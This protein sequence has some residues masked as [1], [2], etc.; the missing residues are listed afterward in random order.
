MKN[1]SRW[2]STSLKTAEKMVPIR[3]VGVINE[4]SELKSVIVGHTDEDF[5]YPMANEDVAFEYT[6][7]LNEDAEFS[8]FDKLMTECVDGMIPSDFIAYENENLDKVAYTLSSMGIDVYRPGRS[9]TRDDISYDYV[10]NEH[11]KSKSYMQAHC[12]RDLL[13]V[14]ENKVIICPT[15]LRGR[16]GEIDNFYGDI[17]DNMREHSNES[18]VEI[19]DLR[20]YSPLCDKNT[21]NE[22]ENVI[23][24]GKKGGKNVTNIINDDNKGVSF[25][26]FDA[27]N[28][29]KMGQNQLLYLVSSSGNMLGY[30][31]LQKTVGS[32]Y[33]I[34]PIRG[35]Y[36]ANHVD[37]T[38]CFLNNKTVLYNGNRLDYNTC[39]SLLKP[40]GFSKFIPCTAR[41]LY[42]NGYKYTNRG[43]KW[44]GM[45]I[46]MI[47]PEL[48]MIDENQKELS[49]LL[50]DECGIHSLGVKL[51]LARDFGG[52]CH[53]VTLD[54]LRE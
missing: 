39:E 18:G 52:G 49:D 26:F 31:L 20:E 5:R 34:L 2:H 14:V 30:D 3:K 1:M 13:L 47:N 16:R 46:L 38:F 28:I 54:L 44:L 21:R 50:K 41:N 6:R 43:T 4:F 27:A 19:I 9:S 33:K 8:N 17:L 36:N 51:P 22:L 42:D 29:L 48:V 35:I 23:S 25:P 40:Y 15:I 37:T 45:N 32:D 7:V 12:P 11:F 10:Q 53:C 24:I